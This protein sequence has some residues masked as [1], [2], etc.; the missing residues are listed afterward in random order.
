MKKLFNRVFWSLVASVVF[1]LAAASVSAQTIVKDAQGN[2]AA[3]K[4]K[5][6]S[7]K[8]ADL[9]TGKTFTDPKG[10]VWPVYKSSTGRLYALRVS[11]SGTKYKQY[12]DR[13][14][15]APIL[16]DMNGNQ[17]TH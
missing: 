4:A 13:P 5:K 14:M 16:V 7:T 3:V 17:L 2:Y 8:S 9:S 12:L 11:N 6:D 10:N 1:M 15:K